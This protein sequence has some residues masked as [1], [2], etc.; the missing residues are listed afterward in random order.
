MANIITTL[1]ERIEDYRKE[2]KQPC[3]NYGSQAAAEK[4]TLHIATKAATNFTVPNEEIKPASYVVFFN[5]A[6][7]RWVG[8]VDMSELIRRPTSTGGYLG[9]CTGFF[10]Y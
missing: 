8:A 1:T 3:K 4:A 5:E 2:N 6:W 10:T 7:G 9:V